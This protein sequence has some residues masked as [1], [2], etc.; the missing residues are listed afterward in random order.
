VRAET[1]LKQLRHDDIVAAIREAEMLTSGEIRV[2][3]S[4]KD[5]A[6]PVEVAKEHFVRMK[7]T[8]TQERNGVLIF[9]APTAQK[10][11]VIGDVAVHKRCGD[12]FWTEMA[13]EISGHFRESKFSQ[14]IIHGVK[15][16]GKL[17]AEHFPRR[18][19]DKNELSDEVERD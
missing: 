15:K 10:F 13:K 4:Q 12:A 8:E 16:A 18:P 19:D 11:A 7:M 2:F 17:L 9:V 6:D 5:V 1:F 3:I 14:G